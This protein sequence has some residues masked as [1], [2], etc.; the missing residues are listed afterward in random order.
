LPANPAP[1]KRPVY[2]ACKPVLGKVERQRYRTERERGIR[3][4]REKREKKEAKTN[5]NKNKWRSPCV[6]AC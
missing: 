4:K 1:G 2:L 5:G 3:E 6:L